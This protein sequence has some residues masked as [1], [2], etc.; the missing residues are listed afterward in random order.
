MSIENGVNQQYIAISLEE[1]HVEEDEFDELE[2]SMKG[3]EILLSLL[4]VCT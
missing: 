3:K 1:G 2:L 4:K